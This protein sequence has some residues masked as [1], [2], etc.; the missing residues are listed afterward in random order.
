[1]TLNPQEKINTEQE[2]Q[3]NFQL[4]GLTVAQAT[5]ELN[6]ST[7]KLSH[8]MHLT[9]RS[10]EDA[11]IMRNYLIVKVK[12]AGK[13]PVAFTSLRGDWH[14]YWFLN[15]QIIDSGVMSAGNK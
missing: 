3:K 1:M 14:D 13:Q 12:A 7:T 15:A 9:Q 6:I 2:L 11:W 5:E 8:I 10:F 4:A